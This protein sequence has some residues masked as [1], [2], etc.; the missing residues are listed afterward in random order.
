MTVPCTFH[1]TA[2][3]SWPWLFT[4]MRII[5]MSI[6]PSFFYQYHRR[7]KYLPP[8][9]RIWWPCPV[10]FL[11]RLCRPKYIPPSNRIWWPRLYGRLCSSYLFAC[12]LVFH[13]SLPMNYIY[14]CDSREDP[15][16]L[17]TLPSKLS[18]MERYWKYEAS[19]VQELTVEE[20]NLLSVAY[21]NVIGARRA[22]WR[23]VSSIEQDRKSVV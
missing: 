8:S 7:P 13:S 9:N 16:Y 18:A 17:T 6:L 20:Q 4:L 5:G 22:S 12:W 10:H 3:T 23:I 21:K 2:V 19:S 1:A 14:I 11:Q 15:V